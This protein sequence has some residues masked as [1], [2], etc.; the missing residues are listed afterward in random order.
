MPL[1]VSVSAVR[2][3]LFGASHNLPYQARIPSRAL[4]SVT[5]NGSR[6]SGR[7]ASLVCS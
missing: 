7:N 4:S 5:L 1:T 3:S 6:L 2:L